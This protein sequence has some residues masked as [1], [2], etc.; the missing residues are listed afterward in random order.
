MVTSLLSKEYWYN[1]VE[2]YL[3]MLS[4]TNVPAF[5]VSIFHNP[6]SSSSAVA[7]VLTFAV[8]KSLGLDKDG[9]VRR[10]QER[11]AL[12]IPPFPHNLWLGRLVK[13]ASHLRKRIPVDRRGKNIAHVLSII[14]TTRIKCP[15]AAY[16]HTFPW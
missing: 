13:R 2:Y 10:I 5:N 11:K 3:V 1:I 4:Y 9:N 16:V 15:H 7:R 6:R 12:T 8:A 14:R